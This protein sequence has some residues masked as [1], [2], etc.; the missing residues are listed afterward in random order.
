MNFRHKK[1]FV[2]NKR[3]ERIRK[4]ESATPYYFQIYIIGHLN[5]ILAIIAVHGNIKIDT[6]IGKV[7]DGSYVG[8]PIILIGWKLSSNHG[9]KLRLTRLLILIE[10]IKT[11]I[12]FT[13]NM[14]LFKTYLIDNKNGLR[15][16]SVGKSSTSSS[17]T[18]VHTKRLSKL[19]WRMH[20][21]LSRSKM[22]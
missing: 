1:Q 11:M 18:S 13:G 7:I 19:R 17:T 6:I 10:D 20:Q 12:T 3:F 9:F 22:D 16:I 4:N 21:R 8:I 14:A 15:G 2:K 5:I